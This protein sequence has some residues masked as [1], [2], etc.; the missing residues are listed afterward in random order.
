[1]RN[2]FKMDMY[3]LLHSKVL[4]VSLAF[5]LIMAVALPWSGMSTDMSAMLGVASGAISMGDGDAFMGSMLGTGVVYVLLGIILTLF[6]CGD[7]AGGFAKNIF[8]VHSNPKEYIGGKMLSIGLTSGIF[9]VFYTIASMVSLAVAG[10]GVALTGGILGLVAFL[11][12]KWLV[13]LAFIAVILLILLATR[14]TAVGVIAGFLVATGGL[15]MGA[16][17]FGQML[18]IT[19]ISNITTFFVSGAAQLPSLTFSVFTFLQVL[20]VSVAWI[21]GCFLLSQRALLKKDVE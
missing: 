1:M 10:Y 13:S 21:A 20:L 3:R 18:G 8:T 9:L 11:I 17:L 12:Q 14:N 15:T 4:Y 5:M 2:I 16:V 6:V 7:Y 19:W